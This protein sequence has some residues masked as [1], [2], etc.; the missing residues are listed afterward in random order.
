MR[1]CVVKVKR[2][3]DQIVVALPKELVA[4]EQLSDGTVVR[5]TVQKIQKQRLGAPKNDDSLG[6]HDPWRLLE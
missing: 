4:A 5:I 6:G 2:V 3:G 1:E